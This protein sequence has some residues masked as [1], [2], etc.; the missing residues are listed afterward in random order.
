MKKYFVFFTSIC[1]IVMMT[2][3]IQAEQIEIDVESSVN[4]ESTRVMKETVVTT[5]NGATRAEIREDIQDRVETRRA[6]VK[7]LID[8]RKNE[9]EERI[10]T[11][12]EN[13]A[14][15][16]AER[17]EMIEEKTKINLEKL[18][19]VMN[20]RMR[21]AI[22][23]MDQI[24]ERM[25]SRLGILEDAGADIDE[26]QADLDTIKENLDSLVADLTVA[27]SE[28][29]NVLESETPREDFAEISLLI[30]EVQEGIKDTFFLIRD[31]YD[32]IKDL[33]QETNT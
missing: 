22:G 2:S 18:F 23:R 31:A 25:E 26:V 6:A 29:E 17:K 27:E 8:E 1:A 5:S 30:K 32:V 3:S 16:Q 4:S 11:R 28:F 14:S 15:A 12:K 24:V 20:R 19:L 7:D 9:V 10:A 33:S 21:A 13:I